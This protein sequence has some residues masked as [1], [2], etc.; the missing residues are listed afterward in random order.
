MYSPHA[1]YAKNQRHDRDIS[2]LPAFVCESLPLSAGCTLP[3]LE[4][5]PHGATEPCRE[6]DERTPATSNAGSQATTITTIS[7]W[8]MAPLKSFPETTRILITRLGT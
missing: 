2:Q 8:A 7:F 1:T 5:L 6:E 4:C 3:V